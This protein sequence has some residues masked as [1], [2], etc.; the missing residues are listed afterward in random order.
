MS[1]GR[2]GSRILTVAAVMASVALPA[3]GAAAA[4]PRV[5]GAQVDSTF[6]QS[7][8][9]ALP[10]LEGGSASVVALQS[11]GKVLVGGA[12]DTSSTSKCPL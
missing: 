4:A 6:G 11:D 12:A 9:A 8:V 3:G 1:S 7:G 5:P 2:A 10:Y